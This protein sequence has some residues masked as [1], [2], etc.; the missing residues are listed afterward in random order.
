MNGPLQDK[1]VLQ[2]GDPDLWLK[3]PDLSISVGEL[4]DSVRA[5]DLY[6]DSELRV[7]AVEGIRTHQKVQNGRRPPYVAEQ[8]IKARCRTELGIMEIRG[9]MDGWV[10][11]AGG[12][13]PWI[14]LLYTSPSPR[15]KRQSRMPSSA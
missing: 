4:A 9:R 3:A 13:P 5:G 1:K 10:P 12:I 11:A 8:S 7:S 2:A 14:C 15:D 6:Q